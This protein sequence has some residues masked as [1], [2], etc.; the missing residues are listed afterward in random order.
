LTEEPGRK[1]GIDKREV[2]KHWP[3]RTGWNPLGGKQGEADRGN[4]MRLRHAM[5]GGFLLSKDCGVKLERGDGLTEG[6]V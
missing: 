3:T 4:L 6:G 5:E 1:D 2:H